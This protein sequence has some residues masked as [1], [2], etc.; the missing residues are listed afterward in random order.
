MRIALPLVLIPALALAQARPADPVGP[1]DPARGGGHITPTGQRVRPAGQVLELPARPTDVALSADGSRLYAKASAGLIVVDV[2]SWT[3]LQE[4][5]YEF[6]G[7][8]GGASMTG[9]ALTPDG[10]RIL[11]TTADTRL[12]EGSIKPDG[13]VEWA[14]ALDLPGIDGRKNSFPC[15]VAVTPDGSAAIVALSLNNTV[16][17]VDL[18][19]R[20][21]RTQ[22]DVGVAPF[23]VAVSPDGR[24]AYVSNWGGRR[25]AEGER[26]APSAGTPT[27]IDERGV[28]ASGTVSIINIP[29]LDAGPVETVAQI[30]VGLFPAG[31][32]LSADGATLY[33]AN[34]NSDTVSVID[35]AQE[36]VVRTIAL[37]PHDALPVGSMPNAL[38]LSP[39]GGTLYAACAGVN[40]VALIDVAAPEPRVRGWAPSGLFPT[41]VAANS[42]GVFLAS[43]KGVGSRTPRDKGFNS[44][45]H[46]GTLSRFDLPDEDALAAYT[47]RVIEDGRIPLAVEALAQTRP[48]AAPPP[49]PVPARPGEPSTIRHCVYIIKEN[50]TYDQVFGAIGR[51]NG[52]PS[53]CIY[54]RDI[55]PNH[56][57]LADRYVLLDNYYCN[58]VLSADGHAW[59]TEGNVTP[60]LERS[61]GGFSRSYTFGDDPLS[62]SS[63]GFIWDHV[64]AAGL[65]FRNYGEFNYT[66]EKPD[67]GYEAVLDDW[68]RKTGKIRF[69]HNIGVENVRK[70][71][72]PD[73]PG[74]NM[75]IPDVI[76]AEIFL[77]ELAEFEARG[78]FP[79]LV[80]IYLPNDHT[81]GTG[82]GNPTPRSL[83]ADNDLALGRIVEGLSH[84]PFWK[85]MVIF[86]NEDDPQDGFDH[87]DGH[88][89][90]C[91]V[92]GP[93][94]K[95]GAVVS[96]FYNQA[97]V[98]HTMER[99]LGVPAAH[100]RYAI[101]PIMFGCF[102]DE[103][104]FTPYTHLPN[105]V[106]L[107]EMN[108]PKSTL[109]PAERALAE[110]SERLALDKPDRADEDTLN[111]ILWHAAR[112]A[113]APYPAH[114]AGAH[115]TGLKALGLAL[116]GDEE[117]EEDDEP[118]ERE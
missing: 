3:V 44:H 103:P 117:E 15:G 22:V 6:E 87:V 21:L 80:V 77:K 7:Q 108:P 26:I 91:L 110:E 95:R 64:M 54:G 25:P 24:R 68:V 39:D 97:G 23:G 8:R 67:S 42:T 38:A 4:L 36:R 19:S 37:S 69:E 45:G 62:Y 94:V 18:P 92:I 85:E 116:G 1:V 14:G 52:D 43:V 74:W 28:A 46:R 73:Y 101:A 30:P 115:G 78:T 70:H 47:A 2:P 112:G 65:S 107:A 93:Y 86:V 50:R 105:N 31:L 12:I 114:L 106:P 83:L 66:A 53:L 16:A 27:L 63:S 111:R 76:R 40:A 100:Q 56:H 17:I 11:V 98:L 5:S 96:E 55:T 72:N 89:S 99:I 109:G 41:G 88:R 51:G 81:S 32:A 35:T 84:S 59:A 13:S 9:L 29:A 113:Q 48:G 58:G 61:F 102:T 90:I 33:V 34:A 104:D 57:A 71:S 75:D 82:E 79:N 118:G 60:Y 49:A 10:S 20:T